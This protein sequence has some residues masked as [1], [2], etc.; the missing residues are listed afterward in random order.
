MSEAF[1]NQVTLDC[2]LNKEM[3]NNHVR[4]Q[5]SKQLSKEDMKFYR[6]RI[7]NLFKEIISGNS[8]K[9]LLPDVKYAYDNFTNSAIHYFKTID[10]NDIIQ[11][12]YNDIEK[13]TQ[14]SNDDC[15]DLSSNIILATNSEAD[16]LL[17]RSVKA[18]IPTL[19][20]YVTRTIVKKKE[21]VIM[22][23][24]REIDL[25]DPYLKNKGIKK[26]NIHNLYEDNNEKK[27]VEVSDNQKNI[28]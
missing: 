28:A 21:E 6:K 27:K 8:P 7:F 14:N 26:K 24:Q 20:K 12:E 3:F 18:D 15:Y 9:N 4:I 16:K 1:I 11:S 23:K 19:D 13:K 22:P 25:K 17:M 10:N 2:L 5:K